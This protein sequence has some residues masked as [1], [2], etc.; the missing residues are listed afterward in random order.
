M[1]EAKLPRFGRRARGAA[2]AP[3]APEPVVADTSELAGGEEAAGADDPVPGRSA[4][5]VVDVFAPG[6]PVLAPVLG[7]PAE[8]V[9]GLVE[10]QRRD[11]VERFRSGRLGA[12][13]DRAAEVEPLIAHARPEMARMRLLPLGY[14]GVAEE[15]RV[16]HACQAQAGHRRARAVLVANGPRWEQ[17]ESRLARVLADRIGGEEV[18]VVWGDRSGGPRPGRYPDGVRVVDFATEAADLAPER[19]PHALVMLL[20]SFRA[21]VLVNVN[22]RRLFEAL[23]PFGRA[24]T[25]SDRV[26]VCFSALKEAEDGTRSGQSMRNF[27]RDI[28]FVHGVIT[29]DEA[30]RDALIEQYQLPE[31]TAARMIVLDLALAPE[32]YADRVLSLLMP[33]PSA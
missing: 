27:Y 2:E 13:F 31:E 16:I 14:E 25:A 10:E 19:I 4:L 5:G 20:R 11:L 21:D 29:E 15:A 3:P 12:V 33:E 17:L 7:M 22:C 9:A 24:L 8:A 28:D 30:T 1:A 23:A 26:L 6:A 18:V 32:E